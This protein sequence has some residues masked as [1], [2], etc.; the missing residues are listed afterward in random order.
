MVDVV[1]AVP[2][3]RRSLRRDTSNAGMPPHMGLAYL[4]AA[5]RR[6]GL[7]VAIVDAEVEGVTFD[8]ARRR[9]LGLHPRILGLTATTYQ[10]CDGYELA[11]MCKGRDPDLHVTLGGPHGTPL[12]IQS[13][14]EC[15]ALDSVV[16]GEGEL[17]FPELCRHVIDGEPLD[18]VAGIATRLDGEPAL[19]PARP[20]VSDLDSLATPDYS[21]FTLDR[22]RPLYRTP[23]RRTLQISLTTSRGCP[24]R[25]NFC[26]STMGSKLRRRG[27]PRV[28]AEA[29]RD[30]EEFGATQLLLA[31]ETFALGQRR[32]LAF[33]REFI[34][35]GLHRRASWI[36]QTRGD[37]VT[38]ELADALKEANCVAVSVGVE[39]GNQRVL[40]GIGKKLDL[41]RV[42][43]GVA[44]LKRSGLRVQTNFIIGHPGETR[45]T[46][47]DSIRMAL[48]LDADYAGFSILSPFPGTEVRELALRGD[49]GLRVLTE[50]WR[51]YG[52]QIGAAMD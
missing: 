48:E 41:D 36:C 14:R 28:M 37:T 5:L 19:T 52:K 45:D 43:R 6:E 16:V 8:E 2:P 17:T 25:C 24:Y 42:R 31:D 44:F 38:P 11:R 35:R 30:V 32:A 1:L 15:E 33:C 27:L 7:S 49:H 29:E 18:G 12:P 40:D 13:L 26:F 51:A 21:L 23:G 10:I 39:S 50:D 47:M 34:A 9:V 20:L 3:V 46:A 22:Y 4:S